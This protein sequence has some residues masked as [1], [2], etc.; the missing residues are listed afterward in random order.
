MPNLVNFRLKFHQ[1]IIIKILFFHEN[2]NLYPFL[3]NICEIQDT[4]EDNKSNILCLSN[5]G[6]KYENRPFCFVPNT[7]QF[8]I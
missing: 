8:Q 1:E 3:C 6:E 5:G 4:G 7:I 2:I